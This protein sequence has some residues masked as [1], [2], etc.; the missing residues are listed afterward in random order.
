MV[1]HE[2]LDGPEP[3]QQTVAVVFTCGS[4]PPVL[5]IAEAS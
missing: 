5:T 3:N 1:R 2:R 4:N